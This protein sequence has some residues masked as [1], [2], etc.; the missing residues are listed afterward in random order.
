[1]REGRT[2]AW[3]ALIAKPVACL[4]SCLGEHPTALFELAQLLASGTMDRSWQGLA[5]LPSERTP[6]S[7]A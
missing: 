2:R 5:Q 4:A 3:V 7:S 1:V 6:T